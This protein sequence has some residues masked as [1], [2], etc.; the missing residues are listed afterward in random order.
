MYR[1]TIVQQLVQG[2]VHDPLRGPIDIAL[3]AN[4][5]SHLRLRQTGRTRIWFWAVDELQLFER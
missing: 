1:G 2:L 5:S 3:P 4:R